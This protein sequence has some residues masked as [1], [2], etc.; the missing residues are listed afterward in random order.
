MPAKPKPGITIRAFFVSFAN[1]AFRKN[2]TAPNKGAVLVEPNCLW[3][4]TDY[5]LWHFN[6]H[7]RVCFTVRI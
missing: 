5:S 4:F 1:R 6:L 2:E 3:G 7:E